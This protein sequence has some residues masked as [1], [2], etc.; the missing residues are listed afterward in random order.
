MKDLY[1]Q[2][3]RS[4]LEATEYKIEM[5]N[6]KTITK[7]LSVDNYKNIMS[8]IGTSDSIIKSITPIE[9]KEFKD[10]N[11]KDFYKNSNQS[12]E[13]EILKKL[14]PKPGQIEYRNLGEGLPLLGGPAF[15]DCIRKEL[16]PLLKQKQGL[17]INQKV[18]CLTNTADYPTPED[19]VKE[20]GERISIFPSE[21]SK[22]V[23]FTKNIR[24]DYEVIQ[25]C[26]R[27][28]QDSFDEGKFKQYPAPL[29]L[30]KSDIKTYLK[31]YEQGG[32]HL[33]PYSTYNFMINYLKSNLK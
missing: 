24:R 5:K 11:G 18:T 33:D 6:G 29:K 19:A 4:L 26:D 8:K 1:G 12:S 13:E 10:L 23:E 28:I 2:V 3:L 30:P 14:Y 21:F 27:A 17:H 32:P 20:L 25:K 9:R 31:Y 16:K 7:E 22:L 15:S